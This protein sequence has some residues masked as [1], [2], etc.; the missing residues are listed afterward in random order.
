MLFALLVVLAGVPVS[1]RVVD[2]ESRNPIAGAHVV[3][4]PERNMTVPPGG[5]PEAITDQNGRFVL[6]GVDSGHYRVNATKVGFAQIIDPL[7]M[8]E[9]EIVEG[10]AFTG[11]EVSLTKG[12]AITGR[13]VDGSGEP[14]FGITVSALKQ[15]V[16]RTSNRMMALTAQI[17]QTN[18]L[19]EFRL[20]DLQK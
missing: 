13:I 11:V 17:T 19:G 8:P 14:L 12:A 5:P 20:A 6:E 15:G 10:R 3:L 1:G 4:I 16:D 18:D 9:L 7:D 2:A